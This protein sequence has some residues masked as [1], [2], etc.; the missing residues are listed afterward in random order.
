MHEALTEER[1]GAATQ[2]NSCGNTEL[3][4]QLF[5]RHQDAPLNLKLKVNQEHFDVTLKESDL[6]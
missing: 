3:C 2:A 4:R 6:N 5:S 1:Q